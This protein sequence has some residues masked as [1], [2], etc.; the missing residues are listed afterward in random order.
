[1]VLVDWSKARSAM[2][3]FTSLLLA[4]SSTKLAAAGREQEIC[5]MEAEKI[6]ARLEILRGDI[7]P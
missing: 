7:A 6:V 1:M 3:G 2:Q 4:R 5:G